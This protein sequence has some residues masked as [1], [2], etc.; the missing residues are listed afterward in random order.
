MRTSTVPTTS[1]CY[2]NRFENL[3]YRL[4]HIQAVLCS[5]CASMA[6]E[7]PNFDDVV[8]MQDGAP[9]HWDLRL[10]AWLSLQFPAVG[11]AEVREF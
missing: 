4:V 5:G 10:L 9:P 6:V 7:L 8:F 3:Q 11:W 2:K 1:S